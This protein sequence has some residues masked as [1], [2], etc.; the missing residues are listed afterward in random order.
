MKLDATAFVGEE[1]LVEALRDRSTLLDCSDYRMLFRQDERP[2]G[3]Y[4]V[5][6]GDVSMTMRSPAGDL[7]LD[8]PAQPGSLLGLPALVSGEG[9][10]MSAEAHPGAHV[11]FVP[12]EEISRLMLSEPAIAVLIL[13][14]LAAEVR[15]ARI[16]AANLKSREVHAALQGEKVER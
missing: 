9:A 11:R 5:L 8:M 7:V 14:V 15:T 16:A 10:S 4:I 2:D 6:D 12:R 3:L 1:A 13:K